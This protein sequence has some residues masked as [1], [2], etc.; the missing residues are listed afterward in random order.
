LFDL[1]ANLTIFSQRAWPQTLFLNISAAFLPFS[2]SQKSRAK[3]VWAM[4]LRKKMGQTPTFS[5][6]QKSEPKLV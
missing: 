6:S 4:P 1:Q 5:L 3:L 2:L